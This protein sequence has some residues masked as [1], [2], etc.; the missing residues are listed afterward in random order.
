MKRSIISWQP[1]EEPDTSLLGDLRD[2]KA[3]ARGRRLKL[4]AAL[5]LA[6][7]REGLRLKKAS[8]TP[9]LAWPSGLALPSPAV[10]A[11][12]TQASNAARAKVTPASAPAPKV[13]Q[14]EEHKLAAL[15]ALDSFLS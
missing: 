10:A 5:G 9:E 13:E 15:A 2:L 14:D 7:E 4:L 3:R 1:G 8:L 6:A 11:P 12:G